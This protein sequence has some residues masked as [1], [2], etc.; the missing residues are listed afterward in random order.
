MRNDIEKGYMNLKYNY[1]NFIYIFI[2]LNY[3]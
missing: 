1:E 3:F 2:I